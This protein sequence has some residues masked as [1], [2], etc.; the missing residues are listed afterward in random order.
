MFYLIVWF[1]KLSIP[2]PWKGFFLRLPHLSGN[3]SQAS[4][5]YLNFLGLWEPPPPRNFQSLLW[6]E[7]GY[8]LELHI[9]VSV[10]YLVFLSTVYIMQAEPHWRAPSGEVGSL[11]NY[12]NYNNKK[13]TIPQEY[14]QDIYLMKLT[15]ANHHCDSCGKHQP[16]WQHRTSVQ[17]LTKR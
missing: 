1:Q 17:Q 13:S 15:C 16:H 2:P 11:V 14:Q 6:G 10:L 12:N 7:Y 8:F 4:Y 3:S 9:V 5:I